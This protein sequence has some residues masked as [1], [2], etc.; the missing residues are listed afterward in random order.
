MIKEESGKQLLYKE[1]SD[2]ME[3]RDWLEHMQD[4]QQ[5]RLLLEMNAA[6]IEYGLVL[7]KE[8]IEMLL[9][10][11]KNELKRQQRVEFGEGI[12]PKLIMEFCNSAYI[13]ADNY[14]ETIVRLQAIFY[15]FKNEL[16]DEIPDTEILQFMYAQYEQ[17][18]G[19]DLD[20]L[21]SACLEN[22][23]WRQE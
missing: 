14:A 6:T 15:T 16:G 1:G 11:R 17:F 18:C 23:E 3:A 8:E 19:G 9:Q 21:E 4:G 5:K 7:S 22:W 10:E 20:Y 2:G 12:L 13:Y